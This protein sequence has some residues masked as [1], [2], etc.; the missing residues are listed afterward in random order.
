VE[1]ESFDQFIA[2]TGKIKWRLALELAGQVAEA[3]TCAHAH[4]VVH[5]DVKPSNI[6]IDKRGRIRLTDFGIAR[7]RDRSTG[8]TDHG[9]FIGTP[10]YMSPEQCCGDPNIGPATDLYSLGV[11]LYRMIAG[12]LPFRGSSTAAL[13]AGITQDVPV[14]LNKLMAD[15]PDDVARLVARLL[16]KDPDARPRSAAEVSEAIRGLLASGGGASAMPDALDA[17]IREQGKTRD[18]PL[19]T[20]TPREKSRGFS[21]QRKRDVKYQPIS[22][23]A[24]IAAGVVA[25]VSLAGAGY[26][27]FLA[28][29]PAAHAAPVW[30]EAEFK[31]DRPG[32]LLHALPSPDWTVAGLSWDTADTRVLLRLS[33]LPRT[34]WA[35]GE[36]FVVL[37]PEDETALLPLPPRAP[38]F[39]AVYARNAVR[40]PR[41][42]VVD[43]AFVRAV[44]WGRPGTRRDS[45]ALLRHPVDLYQHAAAPDV[46]LT[47]RGWGHVEAW[48][49]RSD[50]AAAY[51]LAPES[52][53]GLLYRPLS[54]GGGVF[55]RVA[56]DGRTAV[57]H[58]EERE[59]VPGSLHWARGNDAAWFLCHEQAGRKALCRLA[60]LDE[61]ARAANVVLSAGLT[62]RFAVSPD[63]SRLVVA[64]RGGAGAT[65]VLYQSDGTLLSGD[66][67]AGGIHAECWHPSGRYFLV[68]QGEEVLVQEAEAPWRRSVLAR[69]NGRV[70]SDAAVSSGGRWAVVLVHDG[71]ETQV[72]FIDL[73]SQ[74]VAAAAPNPSGAP[75]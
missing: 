62:E 26:W 33:G 68:T 27:N 43:G 34:N 5:R 4:G 35:G 25:M 59:L 38:L 14:R 41:V 50:R 66:L 19:A 21:F 42:R 17:F 11:T 7:V 16:E 63:A 12:V 40:Q 29:P 55:S 49:E 1:G 31:R 32:V 64:T 48:E 15:T 51:L 9:Q 39:D 74:L 2:R 58:I 28:G 70:L 44:P 61:S 69:F 52:C 6:L 3:L 75:A 54:E 67:A 30:P 65:P 47:V 20:P 57:I 45:V 18:L 46:I 8:L 24:K 10:E 72:A 23:A 73:S 53:G 60:P 56:A 13:V 36:A 71:A 22:R 37:D